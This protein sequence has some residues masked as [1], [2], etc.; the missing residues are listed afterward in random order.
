MAVSVGLHE[1]VGVSCKHVGE[2][3]HT[4][5]MSMPM[6]CQADASGWKFGS[7][8]PSLIDAIAR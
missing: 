6:S 7:C 5:S 4:P 8:E 2:F 3:V 1:T